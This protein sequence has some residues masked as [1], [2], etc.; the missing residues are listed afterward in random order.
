MKKFYLLKLKI[1]RILTY[2]KK[3]VS[4]INFLLQSLE[5]NKSI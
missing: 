4:E 2:F 1:L 5:E 3:S